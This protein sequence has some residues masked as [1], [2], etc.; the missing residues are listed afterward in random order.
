MRYFSKALVGLAALAGTASL[1]PGAHAST[2]PTLS[3]SGTLTESVTADSSGSFQD[4]VSFYVSS[5]SSTSNLTTK[6]GGGTVSFSITIPGFGTFTS[7]STT[8]VTGFDLKDA[9]TNKD[10]GTSGTYAGLNSNDLYKLI[11]DGTVTGSSFGA[12]GVGYN[13]S[14]VPLP[15]AMF[16]F[17]SGLVAVAALRR[18]HQNRAAA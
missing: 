13:V 1:V 12:F 17:S 16:L 2:I 9:T 14:A 5:G 15:G 11:V 6:V 3:G 4:A 7:S 8:N 18:R 10:F